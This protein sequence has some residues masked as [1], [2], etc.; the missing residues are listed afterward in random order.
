[1][2]LCDALQKRGVQHM[3]AK[4]GECNEPAL[5]NAKQGWCCNRWVLA[6]CKIGVVLQ[7]MVAFS[8]CKTGVVLQNMGS[9]IMQNKG[10]FATG[11]CWHHAKHGGLCNTWVLCIAKHGWC[12]ST[13]VCGKCISRSYVMQSTGGFATVQMLGLAHMC[14]ICLMI[15]RVKPDVCVCV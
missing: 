15:V 7:Q 3:A 8:S 12:C 9:G 1:M 11:G 14:I 6:S 2:S 13:S 4:Q 10:G 5:G